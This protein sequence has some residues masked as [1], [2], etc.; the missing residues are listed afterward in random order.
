[1]GTKLDPTRPRPGTRGPSER[2]SW[3]SLALRGPS[4][5]GHQHHH[6][7]PLGPPG[8]LT[9]RAA[10]VLAPPRPPRGPAGKEPL[11]SPPWARGGDAGGGPGTQARAE[12]AR[13]AW[14]CGPDLRCGR[15]AP[16][17][18]TPGPARAE[19]T[20]RHP[21]P[22]LEPG[23]GPATE[24]AGR[25]PGHAPL[26]AFPEPPAAAPGPLGAS[27]S[28]DPASRRGPTPPA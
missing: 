4:G 1:M 25:S 12:T 24:R 28:G 13:R 2:G 11:T 18:P 19:R 9:R 27:S 6:L 10:E 20:A 8:S 17:P 16:R 14:G 7:Q 22:V 15:R 23:G 26:P 21:R 3:P 5:P